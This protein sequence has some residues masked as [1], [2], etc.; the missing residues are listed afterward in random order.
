MANVS[1]VHTAVLLVAGTGSRLR[2]LTDEVPK[3]LVSLGDETI[4]GRLVRQLRQVGINH[5]VLV[6]GYCEGAIRA[7]RLPADVCYD[8]CFNAAYEVTQNSIS[9]ACARDAVGREPF[10]KLDGDLVIDQRILQKV[11]EGPDAM[12]VAIDRTRP[13]DAEAMKV[14]VVGGAITRFGKGLEVS[15]AHA[16]SIGIERLDARSAQVVFTRI[17]QLKQAG[18][19]DRYYEDVYSELIERRE[20]SA[21][22]IEVSPLAWTEVDTLQDLEAARALVQSSAVI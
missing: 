20:L 17:D 5:I 4:L 22:P 13:L 10:I 15:V 9:L 19:T 16:E 3:A 8:Y 11:V 1:M 6:T 18:I 14:S 21:V 12:Y 7:V 2:P